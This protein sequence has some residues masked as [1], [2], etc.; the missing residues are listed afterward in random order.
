MLQELFYFRQLGVPSLNA[1][2]GYPHS[3]F[4]AYTK[5]EL[6]QLLL[7]LTLHRHRFLSLPK[8]IQINHCL[9]SKFIALPTSTMICKQIMLSELM[10]SA[11]SRQS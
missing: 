8:E 10:Y 4:L 11:C 2:S 7:S 6:K 3:L 9:Y 1:R 5:N